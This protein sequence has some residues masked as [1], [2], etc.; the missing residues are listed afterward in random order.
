MYTKTVFKASSGWKTSQ[1]LF[2]LLPKTI[3]RV[4]E[5]KRP[6]YMLSIFFILLKIPPISFFLLYVAFIL[7]KYGKSGLLACCYGAVSALGYCVLL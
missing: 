7:Q 5:Y 4:P 1:I 3:T 6:S 2:L